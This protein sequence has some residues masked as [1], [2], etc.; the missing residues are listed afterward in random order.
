MQ[1]FDFSFTT[2]K[3]EESVSHIDDIIDTL[4]RSHDKINEVHSKMYEL[5]N[6]IDNIQIKFDEGKEYV[7]LMMENTSKLLQKVKEEDQK[8]AQIESDRKD[9]MKK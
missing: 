2:V 9:L 8:E 4:K 3:R 6:E 7:L 5:S 1:A